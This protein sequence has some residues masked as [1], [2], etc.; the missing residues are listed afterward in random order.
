[1]KKLINLF[2]KRSGK[3]DVFESFNQTMEKSLY[4]I[5]E[6]QV[7]VNKLIELNTELLISKQEEIERYNQMLELLEGVNK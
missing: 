1:M 2:N 5:S 4:H 6:M 3:K 7:G